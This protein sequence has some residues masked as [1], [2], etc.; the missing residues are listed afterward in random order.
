MSYFL[1]VTK[2]YRVGNVS[3]DCYGQ[4]CPQPSRIS[5]TPVPFADLFLPTN[6][7]SYLF[8]LAMV[9]ESLKINKLHSIEPTAKSSEAFEL[10]CWVPQTLY[11]TFTL[12]L[13]IFN[14]EWRAA[15]GCWTALIVEHIVLNC[16][17]F[18]LIWKKYCTS[19]ELNEMFN[20][21]PS[22]AFV[23][24]IFEIRLGRTFLNF[25]WIFSNRICCKFY[26]LSYMFK[27]FNSIQLTCI[28]IYSCHLK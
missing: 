24:F 25:K 13:C 22:W 28:F 21:V 6:K 14:K 9:G 7:H 11:W 18:Q 26:F 17:K 2:P 8:T 4:G 19:P 3:F 27:G 16:I 10:P 12:H 20:G 15:L 5:N 23:Y 1:M